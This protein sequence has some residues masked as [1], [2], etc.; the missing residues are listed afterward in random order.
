VDDTW[1][2]LSGDPL[3]VDTVHE[4]LVT[5]DCGAQV[6]FTGTVRDHAEGRDDVVGLEYEAYEEVAVDR[7]RA[8]ADEVRG[9]WP[10]VRRIALLH[11]TGRLDLGD[12]A[13][14]VGVSA[15]HRDAAFVAARFAIDAVKAS[16]PIWKKELWAGGERSDW[17]TG[18]VP[19]EDVT[20]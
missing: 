14:I 4:W 5:A 2:A 13:V 12:V 16:V 20:A 3:A 17:G 18:A 11:R 15:G 9:R 8:V 1:I 10:E 7:L 19:I 6:V